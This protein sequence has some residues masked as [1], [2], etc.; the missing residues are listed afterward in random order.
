MREILNSWKLSGIQF[1]S[2]IINDP[3]VEGIDVLVEWSDASQGDGILRRHSI[4][5]ASSSMPSSSTGP[6]GQNSEYASFRFNLLSITVC[7]QRQ[8]CVSLLFR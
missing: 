7:V 4:P 5:I 2:H 1:T 3:F 6:K 8:S